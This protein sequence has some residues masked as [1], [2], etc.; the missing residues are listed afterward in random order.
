[1]EFKNIEHIC[2]VV[3]WFHPTDS[4]AVAIQAFN[5]ETD[6][7]FVVDNSG[8]DN[9]SLL[10][11]VANVT[12]INL[13]GNKGIATALN[14]GIAQA[15]QN[16]A[17]WVLT[18]DQDSRWDQHS[19]NEFIQTAAQ[20]EPLD[21][22]GIFSPYQDIDG[23]A[24]RHHTKGVYEPRQVVMCSGNLL[25]ISV[26]E[27]I[28]KFREDF[29]IDRVDDEICCRMRAFGW[30]IIRI[31]TIHLTHRLG[32]GLRYS[33]ILRHPF[34]THVPW[35][36]F[37]IAKNTRSLIKLYPSMAPYYRLE[38]MKYVKRLLLYDWEDKVAKL[39]NFCRGL[40]AAKR[41]G[42]SK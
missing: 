16:G 8:T 25:R 11:Q 35:R 5:Q 32:V 7:V 12:Y 9:R 30:E 14:V 31:N 4:D 41:E 17:E 1:M 38:L 33:P 6:Q 42:T 27:Q 19:V 3:V 23:M 22:V 24:W 28:G 20:Y 40:Y 21:N 37:Y 26:W 39:I 36:Y 10:A 13:G 29:F 34:F 15:V 2:A 18:M